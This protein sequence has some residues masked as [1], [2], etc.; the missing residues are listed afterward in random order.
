MSCNFTNTN[1]T[2]ARCNF[3]LLNGDHNHYPHQQKG[4]K[5]QYFSESI[6]CSRRL[7]FPGFFGLMLAANHP[8]QHQAVMPETLFVSALVGGHFIP[9]VFFIFAAVLA[10]ETGIHAA[11]STFSISGPSRSVSCLRRST[12]DTASSFSPSCI[13]PMCSWPDAQRS[14]RRVC[15][16]ISFCSLPFG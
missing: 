1:L 3:G 2:D 16:M 9:V 12:N 11:I 7:F 15:R 13:M 4:Y 8:F 5:Q 6:H 10:G 14:S